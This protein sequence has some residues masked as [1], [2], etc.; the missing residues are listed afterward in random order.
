MTRL[1]PKRPTYDPSASPIPSTRLITKKVE[2]KEL[3]SSEA[4]HGSYQANGGDRPSWQLK[5]RTNRTK[6]PYTIKVPGARAAGG[7]APHANLIAEDVD[8]GMDVDDD[9]EAGSCASSPLTSLPLSSPVNSLPIRVLRPMQD[10]EMPDETHNEDGGVILYCCNH[11]PR[12]VCGSC[13]VV[14]TESCEVVKEPDVDSTCP[15]CH[16]L[17]DIKLAGGKSHRVYAPYWAFTRSNEKQDPVL[18]TFPILTSHFA[19]SAQSQ[20]NGE[21]LLIVHLFCKGMESQGTPLE[22]IAKFLRPYFRG[23]ISDTHTYDGDTHSEQRRG[24]L[25]AGQEGSA[26]NPKPVAVEVDKFF[27]MLLPSDFASLLKGATVVLLTCSWLVQHAESFNQLQ[28]SLQCLRV[29][30]CLAFTALRFQSAFASIF[31]EV[32]AFQAFIESIPLSACLSI[33]LQNSFH[34]GKHTNLLL[35]T[36]SSPSP[37]TSLA[38]IKC[39][40][41]LW[42]N[43]QSRPYGTS[44]PLSCPVCGVV[45]A[46]KTPVWGGKVNKGRPKS[47]ATSCFHNIEHSPQSSSNMSDWTLQFSPILI[48][49]KKNYPRLNA[50]GRADA[51]EQVK[52]KILD[53][54]KEEDVSVDLPRPFRL[55]IRKYFLQYIKDPTD[56][57]HEKSALKSLQKEWMAKWAAKKRTVE[58]GTKKSRHEAHVSESSSKGEGEGEGEGDGDGDEEKVSNLP[59]QH[60][61]K[62]LKGFS[63]FDVAQYIFK[64]QVDDYDKSKGRDPSKCGTIGERTKNAREWFEVVYRKDSGMMAKVDAA[65]AK[66]MAQGPPEDRKVAHRKKNLAKRILEFQEELNVTMGVH[67]VIFHG[68]RSVEGGVE[69]GT[70]ETAPKQQGVKFKQ[71]LSGC[72][73]CDTLS[74]AFMAYLQD[75]FDPELATDE[76]EDCVGSK[77]GEKVVLKKSETGDLILPDCGALKLPGQKDTIRQI[78]NEAYVKYTNNCHAHAPWTLLVTAL[79]DYIDEECLLEDLDAFPDPSKL[80]G[81]QV[82][83]VWDCWSSRQKRGEAMVVFTAS[84]KGDMR[85][86]VEKK[87]VRRKGKKNY[88]EVDYEA[89]SPAAH[90][91]DRATQLAFLRTLSKASAYQDLVQKYSEMKT[92]PRPEPPLLL[93][94]WCSWEWSASTLPAEFHD[95]AQLE[96][97]LIQFS[98]ALPATRSSIRFGKLTL[99]LGLLLCDITKVL[100]LEPDV[101]PFPAYLGLSPFSHQ[102]FDQVLNLVVETRDRISA[103]TLTAP[104]G[105]PTTA[106]TNAPAPQQE[107]P[108]NGGPVNVPGDSNDAKPKEKCGHE[109][110]EEEGSLRLLVLNTIVR[111]WH[112][113]ED[114]STYIHMNP[115]CRFYLTYMSFANTIDLA[116]G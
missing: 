41:Y 66:W 8:I 37:P 59:P 57:E 110:G 109:D 106:S 82:K 107:E 75:E 10:E 9:G 51:A 70:S 49:W 63:E 72:K 99:A 76:E 62:Y 89:Q 79:P 83:D 21:P 35:F 84:K 78:V 40:K 6:N 30:H 26:R 97:A 60:M 68:H 114:I 54:I 88:V 31:M 113:L 34:I 94:P 96:A 101:D 95:I 44:L 73:N 14:P 115:S 92:T 111:P 12:V 28:S 23:Q 42:W 64:K 5:N 53:A 24:N 47:L 100:E 87:R 91:S 4:S 16:K 2:K 55:A 50:H 3:S 93:E 19:M 32:L 45:H 85:A 71:H 46:W 15:G 7:C 11:C 22:A 67:C 103:T 58:S 69:V 17:T 74:E 77:K 13:L 33:T 86:E 90:S 25:F 80:T 20:V 18:P 39:E 102:H 52:E 108:V 104:E 105:S 98:K 38:K 56:L 43:T 48:S 116:Q 29:S 65:K 112:V 1:H 27:S 61:K 36:L 81:T